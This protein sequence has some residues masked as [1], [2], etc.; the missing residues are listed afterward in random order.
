MKNAPKILVVEDDEDTYELYSEILA[1]AGYSVIGANNGIEAVTSALKLQPQLIVMDVAL[2]G[3][4]GLEAAKL[5]KSD[6]RSRHI[7]ILALSGLVQSCFVDLARNVGCDAFL[8]KPCPVSKMLSEVERLLRERA[9]V[10]LGKPVLVVEDDPDIR[11]VLSDVLGDQGFAVS[12]AANGL[13]ALAHLRRMYTPPKLILLDLM[14]PV[15]DGWQFRAAQREEPMIASIPVVVLSTA[16]NLR[17]GGR[18]LSG[19]EFLP[20]PIDFP[21][22]V[23]A[24]SRLA[25]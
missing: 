6:R 15:M 8:T 5:L 7:P 11:G 13:E 20:K 22:L 23:G 21:Q 2:P 9:G 16:E 19:C 14:M 18:E 4:N 17:S 12:A 24:I 10:S 25:S 3:R 1:S